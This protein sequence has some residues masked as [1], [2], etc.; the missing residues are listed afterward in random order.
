VGSTDQATEVM[1]TI[2]KIL[3]IS[4]DKLF[5]LR[6]G[7]LA[8]VSGTYVDPLLITS[9]ATWCSPSFSCYISIWIE[10]WMTFSLQNNM[11]YWKTLSECT[12]SSSKSIEREHQRKLQTILGGR[13]EVVTDLG[14]IDLLTNTMIIEIKTYNHWKHAIGQIL[15]Y[16]NEYP[17][18]VRWIYLFYVPD[19]NIMTKI[20]KN[21]KRYRINVGVL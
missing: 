12:S 21:C 8:E 5:L 6:T 19:E 16:S 10:E 1:S 17:E 15:L 4:I 20:K 2:S 9:I 11:K 13:I 18:H 3:D 14:N 7:G